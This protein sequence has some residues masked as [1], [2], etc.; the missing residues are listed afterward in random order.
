MGP[1]PRDDRLIPTVAPT[2]ATAV[3]RPG[4]PPGANSGLR[5][6]GTGEAVV[7]IEVVVTMG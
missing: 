4:G 3:K 2:I 5:H 6:L 7:V 1:F